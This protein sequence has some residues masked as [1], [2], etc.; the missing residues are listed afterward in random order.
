MSWCGRTDSEH[1]VRGCRACQSAYQKARRAS[2]PVIPK[3]KKEPGWQRSK[4]NLR[5]SA[6]YEKC[7]G[8]HV[9]STVYVTRQQNGREATVP[10]CRKCRVPMVPW[11]AG[12]KTPI[13]LPGT[14]TKFDRSA[15]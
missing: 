1:R 8:K 6:A 7:A 9:P 13:S 3:I 10:E 2:S 15:A 14:I 11:K 5:V 4:L 12:E